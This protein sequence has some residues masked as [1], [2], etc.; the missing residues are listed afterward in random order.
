MNHGFE[1]SA[2]GRLNVDAVLECGVCWTL[3]DPAMGDETRGAAPGTP[4]TALPADW[5]CPACDAPKDKFMLKD[6][7]T[8]PGRAPDAPAIDTALET[9]VAALRDAYAAAEAAMIGL[10]VHNPALAVEMVGF[11]AAEDAHWGEAYVG[12][13]V[14]PWCMNVVIVPPD[15]AA[16]PPGPLGGTRACAFPS[17]VYSFVAGRMD[18]LGVFETCSLFSPM[19]E[20][21]DPAVARLAAEAAIDGLFTAPEPEEAAK[22]PEVSR[23]FL[24]TTSRAGPAPDGERPGR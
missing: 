7:G 23:R 2:A 15:R 17:G 21:D 9:R 3:Y 24:F 5:R 10:P 11:R 4:F 8:D 22:G 1:S 6:P 19:D 18:G 20:F 16:P 13:A 14:T 12:V